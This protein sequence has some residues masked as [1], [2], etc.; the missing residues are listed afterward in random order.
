M[1]HQHTTSI[2][3]QFSPLKQ[4]LPCKSPDSFLNL[5]LILSFPILN[6]IIHSLLFLL[7]LFLFIFIIFPIK[8][9]S[10]FLKSWPSY[11]IPFL[12][13]APNTDSRNSNLTS[14]KPSSLISHSSKSLSLP[15]MFSYMRHTPFPL[16]S[17][18]LLSRSA[19]QS[20]LQKM[21]V[22]SNSFFQDHE[23]Q[24]LFPLCGDH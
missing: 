13:T 9:L 5:A 8:S 1:H 21:T 16:V 20:I 2:L 23:V 19:C 4:Q 3:R 12:F 22:W 15:H 7:L 14:S 18:P 6:H 17:M 10:S 24:G 11:F